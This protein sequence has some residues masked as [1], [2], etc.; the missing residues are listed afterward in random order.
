M[1]RVLV[2]QAAVEKGNVLEVCL[3]RGDVG[4]FTAFFHMIRGCLFWFLLFLLFLLLD[5][6]VLDDD[7]CLE[8]LVPVIGGLGGAKQD[9]DALEC[10]EGN[11]EVEDVLPTELGGDRSS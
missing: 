9:E 2:R 1:D 4:R 10:H 5:R 6:L 8:G 3:L 11:V 7:V